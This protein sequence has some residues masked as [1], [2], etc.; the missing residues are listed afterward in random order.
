[1]LGDINSVGVALG[2]IVTFWAYVQFPGFRRV[3]WLGVF[4]FLALFGLF[5]LNI[6]YLVLWLPYG[7]A[8]ALGV[9]VCVVTALLIAWP[10]SDGRRERPKTAPT[11][12]VSS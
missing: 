2:T 4:A 1:M 7:A 6:Y 8:Q 5:G 11:K 10:V 12:G 3:H 9:S